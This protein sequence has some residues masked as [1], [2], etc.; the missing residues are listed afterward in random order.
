MILEQAFKY[1]I[2]LKKQNDELLLNGGNQEQAE[3]IK[4][5]RKQLD[6]LQKENAR[7][8]ELLKAN[9]ICFYDDPTI[10]WK[11]NFKSSRVA[12]VIP[13]NQVQDSII[14]YPNGN[15]LGGSSSGIPVQNITFNVGQNLQKQTANVIPVQRTCNITTPLT[16]SSIGPVQNVTSLHISTPAVPS[17]QHV[18]NAVSLPNNT[19]LSATA[20]TV[21]SMPSAVSTVSADMLNSNTQGLVDCQ[22]ASLLGNA[23]SKGSNA[24]INSVPA[25]PLERS[26]E[27]SENS[28]GISSAV[29][30]MFSTPSATL[31]NSSVTL[32]DNSS[33]SVDVTSSY[34]VIPLNSSSSICI[35]RDLA[36]PNNG[37]VVASSS[38]NLTSASTVTA[39]TLENCWSLPTS[40][41]SSG[42]STSDTKSVNS[43]TRIT[44]S[45]N[46][47]TTWTTLQLAGNSVQPLSQTTPSFIPSLLNDVSGATSSSSAVDSRQPLPEVNLSNSAVLQGVPVQNIQHVTVTMPSVQP[48]SVQPLITPK[49]VPPQPAASILPLHSAV[50]MIQV[51]QQVG[52]SAPP[53]P[54][55]QNVIILQPP[56][57]A[58]APAAVRGAVASQP[59]G[60]QIVIIQTANQNPLPVLPAQ[61]SAVRMP[62]AGSGQ[63]VGTSNCTQ[64]APAGQTLNGKCFVLILPKPTSSSSSS[65]T[66]LSNS[67]TM[68]ANT[69]QQQTISLSGQLFALQPVIPSG[70]SNVT[71]MQIIQPTTSEDPNTN[72]ALN[73]FGAL[74]NL[75]QSISQMAR[76]SCLLPAVGQASSVPEAGTEQVVPVSSSIT[77]VSTVTACQSVTSA[78]CKLLQPPANSLNSSPSKS[79]AC[80][81][82]NA[83]P[84]RNHKKNAAK[85]LSSK[86]AISTDKAKNSTK[87]GEKVADVSKNS[88][89]TEGHD[90]KQNDAQ[91]PPG[92]QENKEALN[93]DVIISSPKVSNSQPLSNVYSIVEP[94]IAVDT[95]SSAQSGT[96][97]Q[98]E[99]LPGAH[100]SSAS[101][102]HPHSSPSDQPKNPAS[103][104][105]SV[106]FINV[107]SEAS[108]STA[109]TVPYTA[110]PSHVSTPLS[111]HSR[112]LAKVLNPCHISGEVRVSLTQG[113]EQTVSAVHGKNV[114][115]EEGFEGMFSGH[116]KSKPAA[117]DS[118][119]CVQ[120]DMQSGF[121]VHITESQ[122]S[123]TLTEKHETLLMNTENQNVSQ[124]H[125][126]ISDQEIAGNHLLTS[127]QIDSPMSTSSGSSHSFSVASMLPDV[128]R[129]DVL[130]SSSSTNSFSSCTFPEP[131]DIVALAARAI[132][133]QEAMGKRKGITEVNVTDTVNKSTETATPKEER[134]CGKTQEAKN[135]SQEID[136]LAGD[137]QHSQEQAQNNATRQVEKSSCSVRT[138][139]SNVSLDYPSA[140]SS[141]VVGVSLSVNSLICHPLSTCSNL[142]QSSTEQSV[143]PNTTCLPISSHTYTG[144]SAGPPV[145]QDYSQ[146]QLNSMRTSV[147]TPHIHDS[148]MKQ[149]PENRKDATKRIVHDDLLLSAAKRQKPCQTPSVRV[150]SMPPIS[151]ASDVIP[152]HSQLLVNQLPSSSSSSIAS[153]SS[154]GHSDGLGTLFPSNNGFVNSSLR[155]TEIHCNSQPSVQEQQ[156]QTSNQHLQQHHQQ[157]HI[158]THSLSHLHNSNPF[159][160]QHQAAQLR[161]RH[162]LYQLQSVDSSVL[163]QPPHTVHQQRTMPQDVQMQKKRNIVRGTH[164]A[165]IPLQQ[166]QHQNRNE[167]AQ[168]KGSQSHHQQLQQ[169]MQHHFGTSHTEKGCDNPVVSRSHHSTHTQSHLSQDIMHQQPQQQQQDVG[170]RQQGSGA[171]VEHGSGQNTIQRLMTSRALEQQVVSQPSIVSRPSD[172]SCAPHRQE[173]NRVSSYS[174]EALIGK[175]PSNTEQRMGISIQGSR[176]PEQ[177]E[178]RNF[179]DVSRTKSVSLHSMQSRMPVDHHVSSEVQR[180]SD[181]QP[182]K[183]SNTNQQVVG[184]FDVQP[185]RS[186]EMANTVPSHRALQSQGFHIQ[187]GTSSVDRQ[188]RL[189]YQ[190]VQGIPVG[191]STQQR[192]ADG[193]CHQGFMQNLLPS[194]LADQI[195]GNPRTVSDHQRNT[196]CG[197]SSAIEYSCPPPRDIVHIR[198]DSEGQNRESCDMS[199]GRSNSLN[200]PFS[201]SSGDIQCRNTSPNVSVQKSNSLR[202][203]ESQG[204]KNL[205]NPQVSA[206]MH[207]VVR[208]GLPHPAVSHGNTEQGQSSVHQTNSSVTQRS[209]QPP[210]DNS[211]SKI[212]Q[213]ERNRSTNQRHG[214]VFDTSLPHLPLTTNSSMIIGRQQPAGDRRSSLVRFMPEGSQVSSDTVTPDQHALSQNFGFQFIPE[215]GLNPPINANTSFIPPVTQSSATRTAALIPVEPQNTLPSFYPPYS[216]AHPSLS[217]DIPLQ[218]F[219][220]QMFT[221]PSTEKP[222]SGALNNR[223]GSILSPPRPV[224]FAQPSF[225]LLPEMAPMPMANTGHLSNFSFTPLFPDLAPTLPPDSSAMPMSPLLPMTNASNSDSSKQSTNRAAHNISHIL[226]H[227]G[228]SAV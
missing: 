40:L 79:V 228:N 203:G 1:I 70:V 205:M 12:M 101:L 82:V 143:V 122:Q 144:H 120:R 213:T 55:N 129:E 46:T 25:M 57:A 220:N 47:Q 6:E 201:S 137:K 221:G 140:Q 163:Q 177:L 226:G 216:P 31:H 121:S 145:M 13:A 102:L 199:V 157:Q 105:P 97:E 183:G 88:A 63:V 118:A 170:N 19:K 130:C 91:I 206:N 95:S 67:F 3:E 222:N 155:Q 83:K 224:G 124:Q 227:D 23:S 22:Y 217:N 117:Q 191:N 107:S 214:N 225:P 116:A 190:S 218:Y 126:C 188:K 109:S 74:A 134:P 27:N 61:A 219:S 37:V 165:Q 215:G 169:Q 127:R 166:K 8:L 45:G 69:Q 189:S 53:A 168:Q 49:P 179:H 164:N 2:D 180:L 212:R 113:T 152:E 114:L 87:Q 17:K 54:T 106:S 10:H 174:A 135:T 148:H 131:T 193:S 99:S 39:G 64:N 151:K 96:S 78:S 29:H 108:A 187:N 68:S 167:Q 209:R 48:L 172:M 202:I 35:S 92:T 158:S 147:Q 51:G 176:V 21:Q 11:G 159:L 73:T 93:S 44:S 210:Q 156:S 184:S 52:P 182:F 111:S 32:Q 41:P 42:V 196:Q 15:Q 119:P 146:E 14:V 76:K 4:R 175:T 192:D 84:K 103:L 85:Q 89:V 16:V 24:Q 194:H 195:G 98:L 128:T 38:V 132:F 154:Q 65:C 125:S 43:F 20:T 200:I 18:P 66:T 181:C 62:S 100:T 198:R 71:P 60:Q 186:N 139:T 141:S 81:P 133:E 204:N 171:P 211:G 94:A 207:G 223:Y 56:S 36:I 58:T 80:L 28:V 136:D 160:K 178:M 112:D 208:P 72:V 142:I 149:N 110:S 77:P 34:S 197:P 50:Q 150:D 9:D 161:D 5:L 90:L 86:G 104:D 185:S 153:G 138:E 30:T 173:R 59:V 7:Y 162:Q 33:K 123:N 26:A 75:N 115:E